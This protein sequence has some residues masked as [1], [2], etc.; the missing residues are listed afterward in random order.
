MPAPVIRFR[1][2]FSDRSSLG[3]G[4]ISLLEA[5]RDTGSLSQAARDLG[6]SYRRA[7]LL[8]ESLR[9]TFL[10]SVTVANTGGKRGGGMRITDF[11]QALITSY[12]Q[13]ERDIVTLAA[14]RLRTIA[15]SVIRASLSD[16]R[17]SVRR[18]L[19]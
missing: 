5:I 1:I 8:V 11:G 2:D 16:R 10:V 14:R 7:W 3:P 9:Q 13:L 4:K 19:N 12:R 15:P 17:V 6:M 18:K